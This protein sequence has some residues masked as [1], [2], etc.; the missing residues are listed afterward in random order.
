EHTEAMAAH[1][2]AGIDLLCVN[3]YPFEETI[4]AGADYAT[5]VE[6]IDIGGPAMT[7]AAAKNH[8]YVTVVSD[9]ADY[10]AVVEAL[11]QHDGSVPLA[12]RKRLAQKAFART[13]AYDAAVS[14]WFA[15][16]IGAEAPDWRA[17]GG[18]LAEVMRYGENPHQS[19]GFYVTGEKRFGVA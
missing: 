15:A 7:R 3:L 17:L 2:I 13:A 18:R 16:E 6:N 11:A 19:A 5:G 1:G 4:A 14:N 10:G 9:P 8:A 12:L